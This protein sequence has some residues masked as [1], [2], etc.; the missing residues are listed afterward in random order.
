MQTEE[1]IRTDLAAAFRL[2]AK[3]DMHESV[4]NHLSAAVSEDGRTFVMNPRWKHFAEMTASSLQKLSVDDES[5][6]D[7]PVA[8]D[9]SAWCIH[10]EIHKSNPKARVALHAHP[11]YATAVSTLKDPTILPIDNNTARFYNRVA[12]DLSFGGI[13]TDANEGERIAACL[14]NQQVMMMGNHG[15]TVIGK[16]VAQ[17]F[18]DL[19][20]LEKACK[21]LILA[22]STGQPLA[23]L[24]DEVASQVAESWREFKG[25][26]DAHFEYLKS[27]LDKEDPAWR[28]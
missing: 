23:V 10:G 17:A 16:T 25:Q 11:A 28:E 14:G 26:G 2:V 12:Y 9:P 5:V 8:P 20:Y 1:E 15:V 4:A 22:Y 6:M 13:V 27:Q 18:E 24:S 19:Y 7:G 3:M 21:T